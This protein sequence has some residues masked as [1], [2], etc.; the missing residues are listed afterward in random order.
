MT[1][2]LEI[3]YLSG[4]S[5]AAIGP[6]SEAPGWPPQIDRV[7]SALVATWAARGEDA[8]EAEALE[9]LESLDHPLV[10]APTAEARTSVTCFVPPNDARTSR[11]KNAAG[12][13][14]AL[15]SRQPRR[16]PAARLADGL[17]TFHWRD[18]TPPAP[19]LAALQELAR[20]TS[21]VGH[22]ASLTRCHFVVDEQLPGIAQALFPSRGIYVGRFAELRRAF[23][24]RQRPLPGARVAQPPAPAPRPVAGHFGD[25]WLVLEHVDGDM[26]DVR[27]TPLVAKVL[28]DALLSG[29][30]RSGLGDR[31]PEIVSGHAGDGAPSRVPHLAIVPLPFVGFRHADAHVLGFALIPPRDS[32]ILDDETFRRVL[33]ML[34]PLDE[35]RGRRIVVV[36]PKQGTPGHQAFAIGLSPTYEPTPD[37]HSLDPSRY[38]HAARTFGSVTPIALDRHLKQPRDQRH[39]EIGSLVAVACRNAG[40][41]EPMSVVVDKHSAV[42][43]APSAYP[44]G[45]SPAWMRWRLPASLGSRQ[46]TH[47]VVR[48]AEPVNGPVLLG[49]GRFVGLGLCLPLDRESQ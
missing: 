5:F 32:G 15:R 34:A 39:E 44:S 6:D 2:V 22:S 4:V 43:G 23:D 41:P 38:T 24:I 19:T 48:F 46:L 29:F 14:P 11:Q 42:D 7:F 27:A 13:L 36:K 30:Q 8:G 28:R 35:R 31:I 3:E 49:A 18:A 25:R 33:R 20:D 9:W 21:Y 26:P 10:A 45:R 17:V 12:V 1:L 16:F 40:L 37:R 47:A